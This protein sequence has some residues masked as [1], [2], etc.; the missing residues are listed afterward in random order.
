[1]P[2]T[3]LLLLLCF[4][5]FAQIPQQKIPAAV[6][7]PIQADDLDY[8]ITGTMDRE[9]IEVGM[10][11]LDEDGSAA[12]AALS[13]ALSQITKT[14]GKYISFAG[15][16]DMVYYEART[17]RIYNLNASFNTVQNETE[18]S[19]IPP[20]NY[21]L[22]YNDR[23]TDGRTVLVPGFMKGVGA[24]HARFGKLPFEK[25]FSHAISVAENGVPW[26][27]GDHYAFTAW[28][29]TLTKYPETKAVF[30]KTD[31]SF[32]EVGDNFKQLELAQTLK[33]VARQ[34]TDYMYKGLWAEKFVKAVSDAGGKMTM[35][36]MKNY[37]VIWSEPLHG[38]YHQ[39]DIY[40]HG[41]PATGGVRLLE[42]LNLA[43][44]AGLSETASSLQSPEALYRLYLITSSYDNFV[45]FDSTIAT[46]AHAEKKWQKI[47]SEKGLSVKG[48]AEYQNDHSASVVATDRWGN[49]AVILHSINTLNWGSNGLFIDGVSIPDPASFQQYKLIYMAGG[50]RLP[51]ETCPG[52][53]F[54]DGKPV[55]GF[56]CVGSGLTNQ[57]AY[58]LIKVLDYNMTPQQANDAPDI[59]LSYFKN[60]K[61]ELA[62]EPGK[63]SEQVIKKA[64][65]L[66]GTFAENASVVGGFWSAVSRNNDTGKL[67]TTDPIEMG[68]GGKSFFLFGALGV[69]AFGICIYLLFFR[70]R[71][72]TMSN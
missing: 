47:A 19:S 1:M 10:D 12:D 34:G 8:T 36:D 72:K 51:D 22:P 64:T 31:G 13:V 17:G 65:D 53:V 49:M 69:F 56:S 39:Y 71:N 14:G 27:S 6:Q 45:L 44:S 55:L 33:E 35:E 38:T 7:A 43:E 60:G 61:F 11:L 57:S 20:V 70:R 30:T 63:F 58:S 26:T 62:I 52:I 29:S 24:A 68:S 41:A 16:F 32:Y 54:N 66:G 4:P 59:G 5:C 2:K 50:K 46:K 67:K 9:A 25:I 23:P 42:K 48:K 37:E 18:P 40:T 28:K 21:S 15:I 3:S